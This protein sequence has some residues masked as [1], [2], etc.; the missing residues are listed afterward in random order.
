MLRLR[1]KRLNHLAINSLLWEIVIPM[2]IL[3][4]WIWLTRC[5]LQPEI[6]IPVHEDDVESKNKHKHQVEEALGTTIVSTRAK[7]TYEF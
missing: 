2:P 3:C 6:N 1:E 4:L 5:I 7:R